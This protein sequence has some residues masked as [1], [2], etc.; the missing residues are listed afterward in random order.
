[1]EHSIG[2]GLI[3]GIVIASSLF[4]WNSEN[5]TK[6]QKT[7]LLICAIFPP[8]QWVGI[9]IMLLYNEFALKSLK[10]NVAQ[11]EKSIANSTEFKQLKK[12]LS[13]GILT[14]D[15][16]KSKIKLIGANNDG[17]NYK[18]WYILT[19]LFSVVLTSIA[20]IFLYLKINS[21]EQDH[22]VP[23]STI[24]DTKEV[25]YRNNNT[26]EFKEPLKNK[27]F[28]YVLLKTEKP[29]LKGHKSEYY[30][31]PSYCHVSYEK[32]D[33]YSDIIEIEDYNEDVKYKLFDELIADILDKNK[34]ISN[35]LYQNAVFEYGSNAAEIIKD[36][37]YNV[38]I[39]DKQIFTFDSYSEASIHKNGIQ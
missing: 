1:M 28:V 11:K 39:N 10:E 17:K 27:K 19:T 23:P 12:L 35:S 6:P 2:T 3:V 24:E 30:D 36:D 18:N 32:E 5:F 14:E 38:K 4:I 25:E 26:Y 29:V 31:L 9:I 21:L 22:S 8:A 33:L 16:F 37:K 20:V 13:S 7:A 34:F 15:E